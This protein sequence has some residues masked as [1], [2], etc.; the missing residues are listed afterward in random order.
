MVFERHS[1][2]VRLTS[3]GSDVVR[4]AQRL[5]E[6]VE[7]MVS[8][9]RSIGRGEGGRLKIG[10]YTSLSASKL[11]T[12]LLTYTQHFPQVEVTTVEGSRAR[13]LDGIRSGGIDVAIVTGEAKEHGGPTLA[14]WS[15][16]IIVALPEN[17]A[18]AHNNVA[19]WTDL[20]GESFVLSQRDPGPDL[21]DILAAK[22]SAPG[23]PPRIASQDVSS[24]NILCILGAGHDISLYCESSLGIIYPGVTYREVRDA[25]G[26]SYIGY[27]ACWNSDN[28]NPALVRL[29]DLL[30]A[31][32]APLA[33]SRTGRPGEH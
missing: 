25:L 15:E 9:A 17:H 7:T 27:K 24:E 6:D 30:R 29:L 23:D 10:F 18:L 13:L 22:L 2:G 5:L 28:S 11:R 26:S 33:T 21:R 20:K 19:Y 32:H 14:L 31:H 16:R 3:A 1:G 8:T 4:T 12:T